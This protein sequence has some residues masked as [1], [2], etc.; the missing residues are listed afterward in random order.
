MKYIFV[1]LLLGIMV[2]CGVDATGSEENETPGLVTPD[3]EVVGQIRFHADETDFKKDGKIVRKRKD[4]K[5]LTGVVF[6]KYDNGQL[7]YERNYKDGLLDGLSKAWH[8]NGQLKSDVSYKNDQLN[9]IVRAWFSE[10]TLEF[11]RYYE[12]GNCIKGCV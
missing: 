8:E 10:G 6:W 1:F 11:D 5:P 4:N 12:M 3:N 7:A 2:S 9:G